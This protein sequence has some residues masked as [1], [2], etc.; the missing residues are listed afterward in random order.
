M[1]EGDERN[2]LTGRVRR[3]TRVGSAVG[4]LAARLAGERYFGV[5]IDRA[6]HAEIAVP[7]SSQPRETDI[8]NRHQDQ[9]EHHRSLHPHARV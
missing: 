4:G 8:R 9:R 6:R 1:A 3:Y 2:R 5:E 7:G